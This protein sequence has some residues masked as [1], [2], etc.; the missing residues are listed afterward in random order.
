MLYKI[1]SVL[2]PEMFKIKNCEDQTCSLLIDRDVVKYG[3]FELSKEMK[4]LLTLSGQ[5]GVFDIR[6]MKELCH[7]LFSGKVYFRGKHIS[8]FMR[9]EMPKT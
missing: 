2:R 1:I 8:K 9:R 6:K 5:K 3:D 4:T 7:G